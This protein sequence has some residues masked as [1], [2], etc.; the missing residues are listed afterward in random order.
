MKGRLDFFFFFIENNE[1]NLLWY[2]IY[3]ANGTSN[4]DRIQ[5]GICCYTFNSSSWKNYCM[6]KDLLVLANKIYKVPDN[7]KNGWL[8]AFYSLSESDNV[9]IEILFNL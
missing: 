3:T 8:S 6:P 5:L 9:K 2:E 1:Q 7:V 4:C